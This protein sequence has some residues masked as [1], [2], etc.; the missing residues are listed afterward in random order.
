MRKGRGGEGDFQQLVL[1]GID[2][3]MLAGTYYTRGARS[4]RWY[5]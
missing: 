2:V 4:R 5:G 3:Y 1:V